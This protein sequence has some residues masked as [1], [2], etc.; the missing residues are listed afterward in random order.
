[1]AVDPGQIGSVEVEVRANLGPLAADFER[2]RQAA[3]QFADRTTQATQKATKATQ[4]LGTKGAT[5]LSLLQRAGDKAAASAALLTGPLGGVA[6]RISILSNVTSKSNLAL[7]AGGVAFG[8][9]TLG[10]KAAI[11]EAEKFEQIQRRTEAVLRATGNAA[12]LT[13]KDIR[14]L[15]QDIEGATLFEEEDIEAAAQQLLTFRAVAGETFKEAI[16]LAV[17]LAEVG[18]GSVS[19][20]AV[21]MGKALEAPTT[22][23]AA[24][25][26][27]GVSFSQTQQQIIKDLEDSGRLWEAQQVLLKAVRDQV[28]GAAAGSTGGLTGAFKGLG[29]AYGDLLRRLGNAGPLAEAAA[30]L[31]RLGKAAL[32]ATGKFVAPTDAEKFAQVSAEIARERAE[33]AKSNDGNFWTAGPDEMPA[34]I[35]LRIKKLEEY[36]NELGAAIQQQEGLDALDSERK[37]AEGQGEQDK[38]AAERAAENEKQMALLRLEINQASAQDELTVTSAKNATAQAMNEAAYAKQEVTLEAYHARRRDLTMAGIDAEIAALTKQRDL[39]AGASV[40]GREAENAKAIEV[41]RL[42]AQIAAKQQERIAAT[43]DLAAAQHTETKAA[44]ESLTTAREQTA[45]TE[46]LAAMYDGTAASLR[47]MAIEEKVLNALASESVGLS[48]EKAAALAEEIRKNE[49]LRAAM[50]DR[51]AL[52]QSLRGVGDDVARMKNEDIASTMPR[53][54]GAAFLKEQELLNDATR[55]GAI[56]KEEDARRIRDQAQAYGEA[57][58]A[59][60]QFRAAQAAAQQFAQSAVDATSNLVEGLVT[61][62]D[63]WK[64]HLVNF[65]GDILK[66]YIK[67]IGQMALAQAAGGGSGGGGGF[68]WG[69]LIGKLLGAAVG[70]AAGGMGGGAS[71]GGSGGF[72]TDLTGL[73]LSIGGAYGGGGLYSYTFHKGGIVGQGGAAR[74][75]PVAAFIDAPRYHRGTANV[76]RRGGLAHDEVPAILQTGETVIPRGG[77]MGGGGQVNV[78]NITTSDANSFKASQRTIQRRSKL[79]MGM[80]PRT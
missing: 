8:A 13:A 67:M 51:T 25:R 42:N 64:D 5:A 56:L 69:A 10:V 59:S 41:N 16:R 66:Q 61:D 23:M 65:F 48:K 2:G 70:G 54:Q 60:E 80:N 73:D 35:E 75:I 44:N 55:N 1:M 38:L 32:D 27:S 53:A 15:A 46:K 78:W 40:D 57:T 77:R 39:A 76:G 79:A 74:V 58:A 22:G 37:R 14:A 26:R 34:K 18:F 31:A 12:G 71:T 24:L 29:D 21:Q 62:I 68:D 45:I 11:Q 49:E 43:Y 28:G 3:T 36:R 9:F 52:D 19:S 7:L 63:N 33:L 17:D 6:S 50:Q 4:E 30:G 20:N 72:N 47:A